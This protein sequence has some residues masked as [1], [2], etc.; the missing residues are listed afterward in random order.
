MS[1]SIPPSIPPSEPTPEPDPIPFAPETPAANPPPPMYT[2]PT[3][4]YATPSGLPANV[5]KDEVNMGMI[6][7][8]L[9]IF[10]GFLGP[11][12]IWLIKKDESKYIDEQ[13]KEA[14][15]FQIA[16]AIVIFGLLFFMFIPF[17]NI[18]VIVP[19]S[20]A[21]HITRIVF[22]VIGTIAANKGEMYRYPL[23]IRLI[24]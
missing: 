4:S 17:L 16:A 15:N 22:S 7:H 18:C 6:A 2:P 5:S 21:A 11:L 23:T 20:I 12:I 9:G 13:A 14:L 24:K 3:A 10:T 8:L 19:L 1:E